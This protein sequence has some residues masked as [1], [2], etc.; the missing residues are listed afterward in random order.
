MQ[1]KP[2]P[3]YPE[4]ARKPPRSFGWIDDRLRREDWL[5]RMGPHATSVYVLLVMAADRTGSSYYGREL[6]ARSTGLT[7][8]EIDSAL[9]RL[10]SLA[11]VAHKPWRPGHVDGV[12]QLL[13]ISKPHD[14]DRSGPM[15]LGEAIAK[16]TV[17]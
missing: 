11:L 10:L 3:P 15:N 13:P 17:G 4:L 14:R 5:S 2:D 8:H 9:E 6:M 1:K 7:R 12:W 16:L